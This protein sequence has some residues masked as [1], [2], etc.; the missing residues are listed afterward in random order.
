MC[1]ASNHS[2]S[3]RCG[4]GGAG[5]LGRG[6]GGSRG[7]RAF[8]NLAARRGGHGYDQAPWRPQLTWN[9]STRLDGPNAHCPVCRQP[10]Y[11][12]RPRN[13][14]C[15]WLDEWG[16]PWLKHPCMDNEVN[17]RN[18]ASPLSAPEQRA[19]RSS[20]LGWRRHVDD[21][22][23]GPDEDWAC[24]ALQFDGIQLATVSTLPPARSPAFL[25]WFSGQRLYGELQYLSDTAGELNVTSVPVCSY[26]TMRRARLA[27]AR[28][29]T[30]PDWHMLQA[31]VEQVI[32]DADEA[33]D[34]VEELR[35]ALEPL[36]MSWAQ[37]AI[38]A[39]GVRSKIEDVCRDKTVIDSKTLYRW[40]R[41][42][43]A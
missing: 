40:V 39:Q 16:P 15:L 25:R 24:S 37:N 13:G 42:F 23:V 14:G 3:C 33:I 19:P 21:L 38:S 32:A 29:V 4:F 12:T 7:A 31:W 22:E 43:L 5:H 41:L 9:G 2:L 26:G 10:V 20:P 30:E 8:A 34:L 27:L 11:F 36:P 6:G 28:I 17:Y 1:N 18:Y 35:A